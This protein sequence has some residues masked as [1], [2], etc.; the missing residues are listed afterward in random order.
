MSDPSPP[1]PAVADGLID[2]PAI[3]RLF[4]DLATTQVLSVQLKGAAQAYASKESVTLGEAREALLAQRVHGVQ[5]RYTHGGKQW[6]DTLLAAGEG[7]RVIRVQ[8][9]PE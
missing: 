6:C 1:L 8:L 7:A 2:R 3:E 9:E 4:A 5:V